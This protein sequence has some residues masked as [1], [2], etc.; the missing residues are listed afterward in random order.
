MTKRESGAVIATALAIWTK[1][2]HDLV[3]LNGNKISIDEFTQEALA[4][5]T[6]PAFKNNALTILL[7]DFLDEFATLENLFSSFP[8]Q[9]V[10]LLQILDKAECDLPY[11]GRTLFEFGNDYTTINNV[12][13]IRDDYKAALNQHLNDIRHYAAKRNWQYVFARTDQSL[14]PVLA[15]IFQKIGDRA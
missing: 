8:T 15:L 7:G 10:I 2:N 5:S 11:H 14:V 6:A 4:S 9:N 13:T 1:Q 3:Y 12:D